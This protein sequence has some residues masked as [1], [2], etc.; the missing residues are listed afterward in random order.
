MQGGA[1]ASPGTPG[2]TNAGGKGPSP[3]DAGEKRCRGEH[4]VGEPTPSRVSR[5]GVLRDRRGPLPLAMGSASSPELAPR[6]RRVC[7]L[8]LPAAEEQYGSL[9]GLK[10]PTGGEDRGEI[11][12]CRPAAGALPRAA[13]LLQ[14][15]LSLPGPNPQPGRDLAEL[16]F[17]LKEQTRVPVRLSPIEMRST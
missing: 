2:E 16:A 5:G 6:P 14:G 11:P 1:R 15:T 7:S 10:E 12:R 13:L 4:R 8:Q 17:S 9:R 3:S